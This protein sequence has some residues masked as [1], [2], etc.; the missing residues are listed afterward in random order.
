MMLVGL[1]VQVRPAAGDIDEVRVT[2]PV[3]PFTGA[4]VI[5][6]VAAVPEVVVTDVGLAVTVKSLTVK[7]TVAVCDRVPLVPVTVTV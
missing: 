5:V 6:E 3:N 2:V 4:T 1:R 7:L